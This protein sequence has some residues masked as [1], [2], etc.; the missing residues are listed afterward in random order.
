MLNAE[1]LAQISM[2]P[3][4]LCFLEKFQQDLLSGGIVHEGPAKNFIKQLPHDYGSDLTFR[5]LFDWH[6]NVSGRALQAD[7]IHPHFDFIRTLAGTLGKH[8]GLSYQSWHLFI[9]HVMHNLDGKI[10]LEIG[11]CM[12]EDLVFDWFQVDQWINIKSPDYIE[13]DHQQ[14]GNFE[15]KS[16]CYSTHFVDAE[17]ISALLNSSS[18]DLAFSVACFEHIHNLPKALEAI[19]AVM[20]MNGVLYSFFAPIWSYLPDGHHGVLGALADSHEGQLTGFH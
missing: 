6:F 19:H 16:G 20:R 18:G 5:L 8:F 2:Q 17:E 11:G 14:Y 9:F 10:I 1:G 4:T 3:E 7:E 15:K 12:P 13:A